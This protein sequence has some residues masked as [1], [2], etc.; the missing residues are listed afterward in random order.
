MNDDT[1]EEV[2]HFK[3]NRLTVYVIACSIFILLIGATVA[4]LWFTP[5]KQFTP[6][7][8]QGYN[9]DAK[10]KQLKI[11]SD[12]LAKQTAQQKA[13]IENLKKI[14]NE[15]QPIT[16]Q[17]TTVLKITTDTTSQQN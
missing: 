12:A 4:L 3:L 7:Y 15:V 2:T 13:Y 14:L 11:E 17:D 10:Y 6:G 9:V 5:L 16:N 1:Y 8:K